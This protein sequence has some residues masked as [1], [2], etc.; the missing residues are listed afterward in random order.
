[1]YILSIWLSEVNSNHPWC[2]ESL[3]CPKEVKYG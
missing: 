3:S 1:M 2:P